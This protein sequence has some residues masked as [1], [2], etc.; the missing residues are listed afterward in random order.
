MACSLVHKVNIE[1]ILNSPNIFFSKG[2][3]PPAYLIYV[4]SGNC[5]VPRMEFIINLLN[6]NDTYIGWQPVVYSIFNFKG[7]QFCFKIK[8][9]YLCQSMNPTIGSSCSVNIYF[10]RTCE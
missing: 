3:A 7:S 6:I 2:G 8:M 1:S 10:R 9:G 5:I 4:A